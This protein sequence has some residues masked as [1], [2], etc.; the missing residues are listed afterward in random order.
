MTD[1]PL[2]RDMALRIGRAARL[3]PD[4]DAATLIGVLA[5]LT[6][7]PPTAERLATLKIKDLRQAAS[8][9]L[10]GVEKATLE[11]ALALLKG[12][13][14]EVEAPPPP[15]EPYNDGDLPDSIRVAC[16]SNGGEALDGHFGAC[17]RFLIYQVSP[18]DCRLIDARATLGDRDSGDKNAFRAALIGD[19]QVLYTLSIGGPAAAQ[20]VKA[21]V[22]PIKFPAGGSARLRVQALSAVIAA[23]PP[24]WLAKVMGHAPEARVRFTREEQPA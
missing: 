18:T 4:T 22:H 15:L 19:C 3:L 23:A 1:I 2:G 16:A 20:V 17:R 10:A 8:G 13:G 24:P 11:Q 7:L 12:E 21:G 9:E 6:G 5:D 14:M